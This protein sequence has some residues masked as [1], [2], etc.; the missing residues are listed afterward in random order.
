MQRSNDAKRV[1]DLY[2]RLQADGLRPD[3]FTFN[4]LFTVCPFDDHPWAR[5]I[6]LLDQME[7]TG[8]APDTVRDYPSPQLNPDTN[9]RLSVNRLY[10]LLCSSLGLEDIA[11]LAKGGVVLEPDCAHVVTS[12][13]CAA[14]LLDHNVAQSASK[15]IPTL[16]RARRQTPTASNLTLHPSPV[17]AQRSY[18]VQGVGLVVVAFRGESELSAVRVECTGHSGM[19]ARARHVH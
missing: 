7:A 6:G 11:L 8:V 10:S 19:T 4:A 5:A 16:W 15:S 1:W 12:G 2:D 3:K 14:S 13:L 18:N 9:D 17:H